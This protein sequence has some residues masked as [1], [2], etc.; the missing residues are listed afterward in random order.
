MPERRRVLKV[1]QEHRR[2]EVWVER[3][4][5]G[6]GE[7]CKDTSRTSL[8]VQWLRVCLP[9]WGTW[10]WS[11]IQED[12][13]CFST[14]KPTCHSYWANALDPVLCSKRSHCNE[15]PALCNWREALACLSQ[16]KPTHSNEDPVQPKIN[17]NK[18][19]KPCSLLMVGKHQCASEI[20]HCCLWHVGV[21]HKGK[22]IEKRVAL[23]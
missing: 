18:I 4:F 15:K 6:L 8:V 7:A 13:S 11:L 10:V 21:C 9:M 5:E 20:F 23:S 14:T 16:R 2:A 3:H 1:V 22:Q 17:E 19:L 12:S